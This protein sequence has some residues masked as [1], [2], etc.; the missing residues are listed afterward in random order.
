MSTESK[1][2][3]SK[4]EDVII[5]TDKEEEEVKKE[6]ERKVVKS[7]AQSRHRSGSPVQPTAKEIAAKAKAVADKAAFDA[8]EIIRQSKLIDQY[9]KENLRLR[10]E[11]EF[12]HNAQKA[13][14]EKMRDQELVR[15]GLAKQMKSLENTIKFDKIATDGLTKKVNKMYLDFWIIYVCVILI[16]FFL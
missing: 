1:Q 16:F 6:E 9:E 2:T 8:S 5:S 13:N 7:P 12:A 10:N 14:M 4:K 11:L 15:Q 3:E